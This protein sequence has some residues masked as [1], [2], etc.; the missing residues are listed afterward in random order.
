VPVA[1]SVARVTARLRREVTWAKPPSAVC[2]W[3]M[4]S[5]AFWADWFRAVML[6]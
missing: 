1:D 5:F 2:N 3:P 6:A 4:P